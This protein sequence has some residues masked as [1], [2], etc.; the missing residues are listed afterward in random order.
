MVLQLYLKDNK[1]PGLIGYFQS[2]V[3]LSPGLQFGEL[4][5]VMK[6]LKQVKT[7]PFSGMYRYVPAQN[8]DA[9]LS[10]I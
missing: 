9:F 3:S 4:N 5:H 10:S 1:N 6:R 8:V 7:D 2:N